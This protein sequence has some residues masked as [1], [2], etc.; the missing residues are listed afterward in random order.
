MSKDCIK[1]LVDVNGNEYG[2]MGCFF[3]EAIYCALRDG[4]EGRGG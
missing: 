1:W 2:P 3:V 4:G